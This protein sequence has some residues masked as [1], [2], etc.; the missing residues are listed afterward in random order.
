M[1]NNE[2]SQK[3]SKDKVE[4]LQSEVTAKVEEVKKFK[5]RVV[6]LKKS[7]AHLE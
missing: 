3:I 6:S 1:L 4:K 5:N 2:N 7:I